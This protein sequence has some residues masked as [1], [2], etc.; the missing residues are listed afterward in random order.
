MLPRDAGCHTALRKTDSILGFTTRT[1][2]SARENPVTVVVNSPNTENSNHVRLD[3]AWN[4]AI[5]KMDTWDTAGEYMF[6][7]SEAH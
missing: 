4:I 1:Y 3:L 2:F 7:Q 6:L 5:H